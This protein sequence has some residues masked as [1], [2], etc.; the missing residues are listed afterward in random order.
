LTVFK[1]KEKNA[2]IKF[3]LSVMEPIHEQDMHKHQ[4][5]DA[6][7]EVLF[8]CHKVEHDDGFV[9]EIVSSQLPG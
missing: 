4:E 5:L 1:I 9:A 8:D 7:A 6:A 2:A 3:F